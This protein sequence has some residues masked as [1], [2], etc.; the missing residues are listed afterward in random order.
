MASVRSLSRGTGMPW[1]GAIVANRS[2]S[3]RLPSPSYCFLR[4]IW[5]EKPSHPPEDEHER[6]EPVSAL[7]L[8]LIVTP[9]ATVQMFNEQVSEMT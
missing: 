7:R 1:S 6:P 2:A 8:A 5:L 3:S 4:V 9:L